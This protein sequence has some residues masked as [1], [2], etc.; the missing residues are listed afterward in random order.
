MKRGRKPIDP[1]VRIARTV[2]GNPP[3]PH[4]GPLAR[5][6]R[7]Q[8]RLRQNEQW[9]TKMMALRAKGRVEPDETS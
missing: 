8:E 9:L 7:E 5:R 1:P 6:Q 4:F 2:T 3:P